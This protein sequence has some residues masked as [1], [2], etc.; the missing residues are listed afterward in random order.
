MKIVIDNTALFSKK[1]GVY[2]YTECVINGL[3]DKLGKNNIKL[4][5]VSKLIEFA[6]NKDKFDPYVAE[7]FNNYNFFLSN[8]FCN[9]KDK[10]DLINCAIKSRKR[11]N[12]FI[13]KAKRESLRILK[14]STESL[15]NENKIIR[16]SLKGDHIYHCLCGYIPHEVRNIKNLKL[17]ITVHDII[18]VLY[19]DLIEGGKNYCNSEEIKQF[20]E[21]TENEIIFTV[22]EHSKN[23]LC[24]FNKKI[25]PSNV[26][27][28]YLAASREFQQ[29][30]NKNFIEQIKKKYNIPINSEYI[31]STLSSDPKKNLIFVINGF[32]DLI[33]SEKVND[34]KLV[35]VGRKECLGGLPI[36]LRNLIEKFKKYIILTDYVEDSELSVL[37]SGCL[38]FCFPSLYEGFGLP[39]LEAMQCGAPVITS[40]LSSLPE[41]AGNAALL[42]NPKDEDGL[43]QCILDIYKNLSLKEELSAKGI[44]RAAQFSWNKC[45]NEMIEVY[46]SIQY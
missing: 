27:V 2:R 39:V 9:F 42:I 11:D 1:N 29:V 17:C 41:I 32:I 31:L 33:T 24:N 26:H 45:T 25:N 28:T 40:N 34:L 12:Q 5:P 6:K 18:P 10:I 14:D 20:L 22:S 30:T 15:F 3:I 21:L 36:D 16:A 23:D 43:K 19:P 7:Q 44:N 4:F 8:I 13:N 46:S 35:L 37:H 38:C